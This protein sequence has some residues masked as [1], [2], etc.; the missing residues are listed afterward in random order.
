MSMSE[1]RQFLQHSWLDVCHSFMTMFLLKALPT[2][3]R[4]KKGRSRRTRRTSEGLEED[5]E[6]AEALALSTEAGDTMEARVEQ[7][8]CRIEELKLAKRLKAPQDRA[9]NPPR[10][11]NCLFSVINFILG[12]PP[13]NDDNCCFEWR[14]AVQRW[15]LGKEEKEEAGLTLNEWRVHANGGEIDNN[16]DDYCYRISQD[17]TYGDPLALIAVSHIVRCKIQ[18]SRCQ[19]SNTKLACFEPWDL[20]SG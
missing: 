6:L 2:V 19:V 4:P 1:F 11:G 14:Q 13:F 17:G 12:P 3:M 15:M 9:S 18:V 8:A 20:L 7:Q 16:W 5:A 10:D